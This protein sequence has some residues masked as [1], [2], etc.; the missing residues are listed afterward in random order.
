MSSPSGLDI[1]HLEKYFYIC[2]EFSLLRMAILFPGIAGNQSLTYRLIALTDIS[3]RD[4]WHINNF[5]NFKSAMMENIKKTYC[6]PEVEVREVQ[7]EG[8]I[9]ASPGPYNSPFSGTGEDW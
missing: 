3:A 4:S 6:P 9:C 5:I 8:L 1:C 7:T 2:L